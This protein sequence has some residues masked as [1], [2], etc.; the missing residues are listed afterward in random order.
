METFYRTDTFWTKYSARIINIEYPQITN[1]GT[2]SGQDFPLST[3]QR[4]FLLDCTF[5]VS[6]KKQTMILAGGQVCNHCL[7]TAA[8]VTYPLCGGRPPPN[9]DC[10]GGAGT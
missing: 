3:G 10:P 6:F 4:D 2:V 1:L 5:E 7:D 8:M 9:S